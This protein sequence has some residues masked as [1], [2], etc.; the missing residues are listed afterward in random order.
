M[1]YVSDSTGRQEVYV[2]AF[3]LGD[4]RQ[5]SMNGGIE[6]RW[7]RDAT[8]LFYLALDHWLMSVAMTTS[9]T[10]EPGTPRRLFE[11]RMSTAADA[12]TRNQYVVRKDGQR[13]LINQAE[14][15]TPITVVLNWTAL[16]KR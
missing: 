4:P 10:I 14:S 5:I 1:A 2:K 12:L 16:L 6:P 7:G 8:E 15:P 3:P 13:L 11:T 9:H